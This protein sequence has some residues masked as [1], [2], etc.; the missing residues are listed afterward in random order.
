MDDI[1]DSGATFEWN[2]E[3]WKNICFPDSDRWK[4][5]W[6]QNVRTAVLIDNLASNWEVNYS[7]IEINKE[8]NPEW[9]VFPWEEM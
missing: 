7:G 1:N 3:D 5:V 4:A 9:V 8:E 2:K 6:G